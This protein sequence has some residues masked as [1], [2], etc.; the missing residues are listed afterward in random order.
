M[1]RNGCAALLLLLVFLNSQKVF[2]QTADSLVSSWPPG[3]ALQFQF[4]ESLGVYYIGS[5]DPVG[6]FRIGADLSLNHSNQ[7]GTGDSYS[8]SYTPSPAY[9]SSYSTAT[10]PEQASTS[11]QISLSV[12]YLHELVGYKHTYMYGGIGPMASYSWYRFTSKSSYTQVYGSSFLSYAYE[13]ERTNKTS[14]IGPLAI[15]GVRSRLLEHVGL[16]AELGLSAVYQWAEQSSSS[17]SISTGS[18]SYTTG[19]KNGSISHLTGWVISFTGI[20]VGL[21]LEF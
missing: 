4:I 18:S 7:S 19:S 21:V 20:Q 5:W 11:Y 3:G 10:Q 2:S 17:G 16:N 8:T 1:K 13:D 14:A 15:L 6:H 9:E 12:L